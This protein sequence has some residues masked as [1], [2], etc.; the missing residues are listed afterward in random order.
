MINSTAVRI[1]KWLWAARFFKT[2][3]QAA[4]A[5]D[6]GKVRVDGER[7][8]T[9][10]LLKLGEILQVDNGATDWEVTVLALSDARGNAAQAQLLYRETEASLALRAKAADDRKYFREPGT[11]LKGRPTKRVRREI[12]KSTS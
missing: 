5:V 3:S 7:V 9:A 1:D 12:D 2:R 8:K 11:T 4:A 10:R 6:A